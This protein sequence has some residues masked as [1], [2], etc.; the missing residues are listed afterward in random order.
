MRYVIL[1]FVLGLA[2]VLDLAVLV[3]TS[4]DMLESFDPLHPA[5][6]VPIVADRVHNLSA[7]AGELVR[8]LVDW[9]TAPYRERLQRTLPIEP[10]PQ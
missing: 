6:L 10:A 9:F 1:A 2:I 7:A 8:D 5:S 4:D 3:A